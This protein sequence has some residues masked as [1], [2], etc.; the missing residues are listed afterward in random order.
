[1]GLQRSATDWGVRGKDDDYGAGLLRIPSA[2]QL[3]GNLSSYCGLSGAV[4]DAVTGDSLSGALVNWLEGWR[5]DSTNARGIYQ[6]APLAGTV[7]LLV[8]CFGYVP[9]TLTLSLAPGDTLDLPIDLQPWPR[10]AL[11]G[12]VRD[13]VSG[14]PIEGAVVALPGTP[15]ASAT[16]GPDGAY[17]F[18][19]FLA[20]TTLPVRAAVFGY[21]RAESAAAV[22]ADS[23]RQLDFALAPGYAD[24]FEVNLG[25]SGGV[26]GDDATCG[27]WLRADPV[28]I[29]FNGVMIQPEYDHTAGAGRTC[30]LTGNGVPGCGPFQNDVDGGTTTLLS[31]RFDATGYF[32]PTLSLWWWFS[33]D[34][35]VYQDDTLR[36]E[37][38]LDDGESWAPV[39]VTGEPNHAWQELVVDLEAAP[40]VSDR[41]R[42][43][44]RASDEFHDS[45]VEVAVDDFWMGT[46]EWAGL[47]ETRIPRL[48]LH[49]PR[50]NP[51]GGAT[52]FALTLS[53]D[54]PVRLGVYDL[55]GRCV[56]V[57]AAERLAPGT[58]TL[59]WNGRDAAGR[60][61]PTG[62]YFARLEAG[63]ER[64][65]RRVVRV[66]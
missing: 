13:A 10:G 27:T 31:P 33:N 66:R 49:G 36:I 15:V 23:T 44:V 8:R 28:G 25:W 39:L 4:R 22:P 17:L 56:R 21:A 18:A 45:S 52:T 24:D 29:D 48:L 3:A 11:Q 30:F 54:V 62:I 14:L 50:P 19:S 64:M 7:S 57:L 34:A 43:R 12:V 59:S 42:L 5:S 53:R 46:P 41:M 1:M 9:D 58:H 20:D 61:C 16:T 6:L 37:L 47:D 26:P 2:L 63:D 65:T 35:S 38:S 32:T 55:N 51:S 60:G 40:G